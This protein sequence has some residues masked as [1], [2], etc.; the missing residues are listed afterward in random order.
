MKMKWRSI[1]E[2]DGQTQQWLIDMVLARTCLMKL[3]NK[4]YYLTSS[5]YNHFIVLH[6]QACYNTSNRFVK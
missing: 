5:Q 4:D 1:I 2:E 3:L 6:V